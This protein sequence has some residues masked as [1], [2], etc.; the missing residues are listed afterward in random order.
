M[1]P[2]SAVVIQVVSVDWAEFILVGLFLV[3]FPILTQTFVLSHH[4]QL[5][6]AFAFPPPL[7]LVLLHAYKPYG[8]QFDVWG[9]GLY[10]AYKL[11]YLSYDEFN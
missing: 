10:W 4:G 1:S 2:K 9:A 11:L 8:T 7:F 6:V 3:K 5:R